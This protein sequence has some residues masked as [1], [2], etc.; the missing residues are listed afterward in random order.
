MLESR[1]LV[2]FFIFAYLKS[3]KLKTEIKP[4]E[5]LPT[6]TTTTTLFFVQKSKVGWFAPQIAGKLV[7]AEQE[8]YMNN[9]NYLTKTK[10]L[11]Y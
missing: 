11:N 9:T 1:N 5:K 2:P 3:R 10:V 8:K 6:T 7:V 4:R